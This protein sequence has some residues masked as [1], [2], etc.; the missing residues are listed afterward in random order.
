VLFRSCANLEINDIDFAEGLVHVRAGK[1][2]KDRDVP[3][4]DD[5]QAA[6]LAYL[7]HRP[8]WPGQQLWLGK[9]TRTQNGPGGPLG[10]NGVRLMLERR[11]R[12][13]GMRQ[14]NAHAWRHGFA[15]AML[16]HGA[17]LSSISNMLG[18]G[19]VQITGSIYARWV[20]GGLKRQYLA[21]AHS[22]QAD[23]DHDS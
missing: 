10:S 9:N 18:H 7:T 21:A 1:G 5:V 20:T 8:E 4:L 17:D 15:M 6:I 12:Q 14:L 19:S 22:I 23:S 3:M 2:N 11:C 16:N 13:A